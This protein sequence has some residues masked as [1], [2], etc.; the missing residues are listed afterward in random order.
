MDLSFSLSLCLSLSLSLSLSLCRCS[1]ASLL[2]EILA[3]LSFLALNRPLQILNT[4]EESKA[5]LVDPFLT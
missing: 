4:N 3:V 5:F 2:A 1:N